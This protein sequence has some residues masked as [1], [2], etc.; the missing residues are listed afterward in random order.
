MDEKE[1]YKTLD[2]FKTDNGLVEVRIFSTVNKTDI[3]SGIFDDRAALV[4]SIKR[5]DREPYNI[6]FVFN[7]LKD[8]LSGMPQYNKMLK[9]AKSVSDSGIK[10]RRWLLVDFDPIR[11]GDVKDIASTDEEMAYSH[12]VAVE[13]RKF[14][15]GLGFT[16]PVVCKS[17]NGYHLLFR[18]DNIPCNNETNDVCKNVLKYIAKRF[19][20]ER[21]DCDVKVFNPARITKFYGSMSHKGGNTPQRPHRKSEI[22]VIPGEIAP[23]PYKV[24]ESVSNA[25]KTS[26]NSEK[27][28]VLNYHVAGRYGEQ[29]ESFNLDEF[30]ASNGIAIH[31]DITLSDGTRKIVLKTCPFDP[32]H[33]KDAAIFVSPQ[34]AITFTCFHNSCSGY[35]WRDLRLKF[36][37]HAYDRK[38]QYG[39]RL[40]Y[41]QYRQ[42]VPPKKKYEIKDENPELGKKW[43]CMSDIAKVNLSDIEKIKTGFYE[44]DK[45]IVG[46]FVG[47]VTIISGNNASGKSSWINTLVLNVIQQEY[48]VALWS[49]ELPPHILKTWIQMAAAGK[50]ALSPSKMEQGKYYVRNDIGQR[51]D[52]W[53]DGKF[54]LYNNDYTNKWEQIF[55]DMEE[56]S[57]LGVKLFILDNLFSLDIDLFDGDKNNKQ[58]ELI[59]QI[60]RFAKRKNVHLI[61]VAHP[62]KVTTLL[63]KTDISGSSDLTNAVDNV[64]IIHRV[65]NDFLKAGDEFWGKGTVEKYKNFGNC[66][67]VAKNRMFGIVDQICGMYYE[68]ESRRFKNT[69]FENVHYGWENFHSQQEIQ[70][71]HQEYFPSQADAVASPTVTTDVL[72]FSPTDG[73]ESP[74]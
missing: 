72:P 43:F 36:D 25:L 35:T 53:M 1:I 15:R 24:L 65:N 6:Y 42:D 26:E 46:L 14:M 2:V 21:V 33:G 57:A 17:G 52:A 69:E 56:L 13:A 51:I 18:V 50:D 64:F 58:K 55:H 48:K 54:F 38:E 12:D 59:L 62:R 7:E 68:I 67:E 31:K 28:D 9:G 10:Y 8:A 71:T 47:E 27:Q 29:R 70:Y 73:I 37:P 23:T 40:P 60:C 4:E 5:F 16:S 11:E 41:N 22:V 20:D 30:L 34:G 66:V 74:F 44:M 3:Y 49:G 39:Q 32:S 45:L 19:S 63:R 61:L